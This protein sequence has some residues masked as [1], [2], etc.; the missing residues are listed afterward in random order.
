MGSDEYSWR[1]LRIRSLNTYR[2]GLAFMILAM[3]CWIRGFIPGIQLPNALRDRGER[4]RGGGRERGKGRERGRE[5]R[6]E[7][8]GG[9]EGRGEREGGEVVSI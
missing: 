1:A 6:G 9:R 4:E 5:G 8:E 3:A 2:A 7:R